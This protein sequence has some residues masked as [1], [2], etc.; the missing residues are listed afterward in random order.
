[1][2]ALVMKISVIVYALALIIS[3]SHTSRAADEHYF[4]QSGK[5]AV[6]DAKP[7]GGPTV[8][9]IASLGVAE[10]AIVEIWKKLP[11]ATRNVMFVSRRAK[12]YGGYEKRSSSVFAVG[13][14]LLTYI[15][16]IGYKWKE[17]SQGE[18]SIGLTID[19]E[20]RT[21]DGKV[22]G[23]QR[24]FQGI[25]FTTHYQN[26]EVFLNLNI[27]LDGITPGDYVLAFDIHDKFGTGVVR[28]EQAFTI[29]G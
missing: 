9:T 19:F 27:T 10:N 24:G 5:P 23:G 21:K 12:G 15:E 28:T 4:S 29:K 2:K 3:A 16:P 26:R 6:V 18:F 1:M 25:D 11:L 8:A 22:L 13:E 7:P 14:E 20:V 17:T